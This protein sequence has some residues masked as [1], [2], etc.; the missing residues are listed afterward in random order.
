MT[1]RAAI[2]KVTLERGFVRRTLEA[3][4]LRRQR[5]ARKL[6][7]ARAELAELVVRG[8]DAGLTMTELCGIARI[9]RDTGYRVINGHGRPRFMDNELEEPNE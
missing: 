8:L 7:E 1:P 3:N 6:D 9:R 5:A 2:D 4:L